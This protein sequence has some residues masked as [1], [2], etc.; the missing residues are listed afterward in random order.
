M[1]DDKLQ[2]WTNGL[3]GVNVV[4]SPIH[5]V[6]GE[7]LSAQNAEPFT[8]EGEGG[9]RKRG[10]ISLFTPDQLPAA[11]GAITSIPLPDPFQPFAV[12]GTRLYAPTTA[13]ASTYLTTTDGVTWTASAPFVRPRAPLGGDGTYNTVFQ[14]GGFLST[15]GALYFIDTNGGFPDGALV[16]WNGS[17]LATISSNKLADVFWSIS[18]PRTLLLHDGEAWATGANGTNARAVKFTGAAWDDAAASVSSF[19]KAAWFAVFAA[20]SGWSRIW[21]PSGDQSMGSWTPEGGFIDHGVFTGNAGA[22]MPVT[23]MLMTP[24]GMILS[25]DR[26]GQDPEILWRLSDPDGTWVDLS[27]AA[28][29][30][31]GCWGPL[32]LFDGTLYIGR[33]TDTGGGAGVTYTGCE[34]WSYDGTTLALVKDLTTVVANANEI[35]SMVAFNGALYLTVYASTDPTHNIVRTADA[36]TFTVP[37]AKNTADADRPRGELG[38]Y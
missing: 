29:N 35:R 9:I 12:N 2:V 25:L 31:K 15:D 18:D 13:G 28:P 7:L 19:G 36:V 34:L 27:P 22:T 3:F 37:V 11:I 17:A 6:D 23:D 1:A 24:F 16:R 21:I 30:N 5:L 10:G 4:D 26:N 14:H 20:A 8:E 38:F 33:H 32:A